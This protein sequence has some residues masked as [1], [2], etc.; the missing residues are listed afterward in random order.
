MS[1]L[2]SLLWTAALAAA[3]ITELRAAIPLG[4]HSFGLTAPAAFFAAVAGNLVPALLIIN[5]LEP[6]MH[7]LGRYIPVV[8]R[9]AD[10]WLVRSREK[11]RPQVVRYGAVGLLVFIAIPLP[12]TGA[13]TGAVGAVLL[14]IT[15]RKAMLAALGGILVAATVVLAADLGIVK[16]IGLF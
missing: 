1:T 16:L 13:W 14:G 11:V 4:I 8:H 7:L 10:H 3:P 6:T 2:E 15:K 9:F 12:L 5:L